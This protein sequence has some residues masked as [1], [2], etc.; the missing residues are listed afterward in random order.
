M[1]VC[2]GA[3]TELSSSTVMFIYI[4]FVFILPEML[5]L[6][7]EFVCSNVVNEINYGHHH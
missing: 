2:D 5:A 4:V 6:T 7:V 1:C 3:I